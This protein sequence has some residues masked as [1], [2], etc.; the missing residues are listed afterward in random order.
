MSERPKQVYT[1][2]QGSPQTQR[3][4]GSP[5]KTHLASGKNLGKPKIF[6]VCFAFN[7]NSKI[8]G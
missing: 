7:E 6:L 5:D 2:A 8:V 4:P 3:P 1:E